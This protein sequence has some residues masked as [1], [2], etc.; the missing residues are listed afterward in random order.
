MGGQ[1]DELYI[2]DKAI[3]AA[4]VSSLFSGVPEPSSLGLAGLGCLA[5]LR[6]RRSSCLDSGVS[7]PR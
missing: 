5:L 1:I 2:F 7:T 4:T 6:R 3:D